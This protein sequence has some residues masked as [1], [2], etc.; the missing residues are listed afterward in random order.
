MWLTLEHLLFYKLCTDK[1]FD[2]SNTCHA[3]WNTT[4]SG[5]PNTGE[6]A[7][8]VNTD[9]FYSDFWIYHTDLKGPVPPNTFTCK[10]QCL[11]RRAIPFEYTWGGGG[12]GGGVERS[13]I[14]KS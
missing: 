6:L 10:F 2:I 5:L 13:P 8:S 1:E 9:V 14:K 3:F 11:L 7:Y 4:S 12:G